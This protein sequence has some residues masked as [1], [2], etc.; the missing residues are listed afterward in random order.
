MQYDSVSKKKRNGL[1]CLY[2]D[3]CKHVRHPQ[4]L[5]LVLIVMQLILIVDM[6]AVDMIFDPRF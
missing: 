3:L 1:Q 5:V 6:V 4:H 2:H